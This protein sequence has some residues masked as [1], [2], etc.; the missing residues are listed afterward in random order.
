MSPSALQAPRQPRPCQRSTQTGPRSCQSHIR[1]YTHI[2][3]RD[4]TP[5]HTHANV[6][7]Q[8]CTR[9]P[10]LATR[11]TTCF[12]LISLDVL[13]LIR[14]SVFVLC[15]FSHLTSAVKMISSNEFHTLQLLSSGDKTGS[16][17]DAPIFSNN[18]KSHR[19]GGS[20]GRNPGHVGDVKPPNQVP[21]DRRMISRVLLGAVSFHQA[22]FDGARCPPARSRIAPQLFRMHVNCR[23]SSQDLDHGNLSLSRLP[24]ACEFFIH[25][26][27]A[28]IYFDLRD[29]RA[30]PKHRPSNPQQIFSSFVSTPCFRSTLVQD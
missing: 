4:A 7:A 14:L 3:A 13:A 19:E 22:T 1:K 28:V 15:S 9:S 6:S 10:A 12:F 11:T 29:H 2:F 18:A 21:E 20:A 8:T 23:H 25:H 17:H 26:K 16:T 5:S 24:L 30:S 27:A